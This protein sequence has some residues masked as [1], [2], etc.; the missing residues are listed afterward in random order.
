[1]RIP[2]E[3][4]ARRPTRARRVTPETRW[5]PRDPGISRMRG[6]E[7]GGGERDWDTVG[8]RDRI[9]I[10]LKRRHRRGCR[11]YATHPAIRSPPRN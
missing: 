3:R 4:G 2:E 8:H 1:M 7:G 10:R 9:R 6:G 11:V 5:V